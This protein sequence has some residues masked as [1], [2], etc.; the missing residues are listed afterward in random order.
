MRSA[1]LDASAL[2]AHVLDESGISVV[3]SAINAGAVI[4]TVNLS[5]VM[6][7]LRENDATVAAIH[8]ALDPLGIT[9]IV[10]R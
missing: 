5:E 4:G 8:L 9:I 7:Q 2:L 1:V 6:A 10:I 3:A